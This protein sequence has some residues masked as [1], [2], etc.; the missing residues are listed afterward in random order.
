MSLADM[1]WS[2]VIAD[3]VEANPNTRIVAWCHEDTPFIWSE[4]MQELTGHDPY[5]RL[6]GEFDMLGT[7]ISEEGMARLRK[8]LDGR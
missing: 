5:T 7:I 4:I 1:L 3:I 8:F 6:V 2:E